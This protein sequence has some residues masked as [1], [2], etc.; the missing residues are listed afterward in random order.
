MKWIVFAIAALL[1]SAAPAG[2]AEGRWLRAESPQFVVYGEDDEASLVAAVRDLEALDGLLRRMTQT[3]APPSPVRLEVYLFKNRRRLDVLWPNASQNYAGFYTARPDLIAAFNDYSDGE[4]TGRGAAD[5]EEGYGKIVLY[6]EYAHHFMYQYFSNAY[7][8]WY[9]EGFADYI[10][11]TRF[12]QGRIEVG[13]VP[14]VRASW[15]VAGDWMDIERFLKGRDA[16]FTQED[17]SQF[18]AQA[19]LATHYLVNTP[20][21]MAGFLRYVAAIRTG[22]DAVAAFQPAFG[23]T[24]DAFDKELRRYKRAQLN[25][26]AL[27]RPASV[28]QLPVRVSR[29][30]LSADELLL[31]SARVRMGNGA[32]KLGEIRAIAARFPEDAYAVRVHATA[33][34]HAG[35]PARA[36]PLLDGLLAKTPDDAEAL[37]LKGLA[38][39]KQAWK[40]GADTRGL[41]AQARPLLAR[42]NRLTPDN[43][44]ILFRYAEATNG[45][46]GLSDETSLNVL[47]LAQQLAPQVDHYRINA[48]SALMSVER[49]EEAA[50]LLMPLAFEPH[51]GEQATFARAM[52]EA[53]RNKR[54]YTPKAES[55]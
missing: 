5:R 39:V 47:L 46:P 40:P 17:I 53:A 50:N 36:V 54:P 30:P 35:E 19:W 3:N 23:I 48:A 34:I 9:T 43:P 2:A 24:P 12:V 26:F 51:G 42:A 11:N 33:E 32:E 20:E 49:Y 18:Y 38:L 4:S 37:Y 45:Q 1:L 22:G 29:M 7:P 55:E 21:R 15:L 10:S 16:S 52:L 27:T 8:G 28:E 31:L 44:H 41:L 14:G 25:A 6:H 13:R